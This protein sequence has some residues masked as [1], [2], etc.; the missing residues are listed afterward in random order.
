MSLDLK[1]TNLSAKA[2]AGFEFEVTIPE[3]FEP[4][5][6]FVTV[7]GD[8]SPAV[9]AYGRRKF[10]EFQ[11]KEAQAKRRGKDVEQMTLD[12]AEELAVES[13]IVRIIGW[14]GLTEDGKEVAFTPENATRVLT[15]HAWI[16]EQ[17]M[18]EASTLKNFL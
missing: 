15:D 7:R 6:F 18:E 2:E 14:K 16:R 9:K 11:L 12:E 13:C 1:K 5:G 17:I 3:T 4:T 8:N 10:Q